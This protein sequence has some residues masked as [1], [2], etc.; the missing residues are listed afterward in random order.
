MDAFVIETVPAVALGIFAVPFEILLAVIV[1]HVVLAGDKE[2]LA[3]VNRFKG[4]IE[5]VEF[6]ALRKLAEISG[7]KHEFG[8]LR[9]RVE[10]R[11]RFT[12]SGCY[13]RISGFVEP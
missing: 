2:K 1:Q 5:R 3:G 7:M 11:N 6:L 12:Q 8:R 4:L 13:V 9:K 10:F